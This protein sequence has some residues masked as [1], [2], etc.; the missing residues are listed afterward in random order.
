MLMDQTSSPC[1][2]LALSLPSERHHIHW[3]RP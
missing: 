3:L 1:I 2:T